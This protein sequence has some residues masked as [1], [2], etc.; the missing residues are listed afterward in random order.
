M[1]LARDLGTGPRRPF[2]SA[3]KPNRGEPI[4]LIGRTVKPRSVGPCR[5]CG[6]RNFF[7]DCEDEQ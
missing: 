3:L 4:Q 5:V 2:G 1:T 6:E 7:C